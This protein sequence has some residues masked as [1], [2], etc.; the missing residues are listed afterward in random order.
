MGRIAQAF[1]RTFHDLVPLTGSFASG[2]AELG[3]IRLAAPDEADEVASEHA[4]S[5]EKEAIVLVPPGYKYVR[6]LSSPLGEF[7]LTFE[8]AGGAHLS[9]APLLG[10]VDLSRRR[11]A[12]S[13]FVPSVDWPHGF[14]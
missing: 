8:L 11:H 12:A 13:Q 3:A 2:R 9:G 5:F 4:D 6:S 14:E 7:D 1:K 10:D